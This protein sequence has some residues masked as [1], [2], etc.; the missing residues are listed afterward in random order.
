[1]KSV[2]TWEPFSTL[3]RKVRR[4]KD[5]ARNLRRWERKIEQVCWRIC[6]AVCRS[7]MVPGGGGGGGRWWRL[8]MAVFG[9]AFYSCVW[10]LGKERKGKKIMREKM[11][12]KLR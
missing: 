8:F 2:R 1:M 5:R 6:V 9:R 11:E 10:E 3:E 7:R 12:E 4:R